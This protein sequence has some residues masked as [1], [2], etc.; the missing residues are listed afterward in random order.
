MTLLRFARFERFVDLSWGVCFRF[1]IFYQLRN[2]V[3]K[4][5]PNTPVM[6]HDKPWGQAQQLWAFVRSFT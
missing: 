2:Y 6:P 3:P 4:F 5:V 1:L